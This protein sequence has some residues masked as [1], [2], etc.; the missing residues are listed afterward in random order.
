MEMDKGIYGVARRGYFEARRLPKNL[1][2]YARSEQLERLYAG[3]NA[4]GSISQLQPNPNGQLAE[5]QYPPY[6]IGQASHTASVGS[7]IPYVQLFNRDTVGKIIIDGIKVWGSSASQV[8]MF[9]VDA[10]VGSANT[11][12][13]GYPRN[14]SYLRWISAW[15]ECRHGEALT[16]FTGYDVIGTFYMAAN[17]PVDCYRNNLFLDEF[18]LEP[19]WG[20]VLTPVLATGRFGIVVEFHEDR[21]IPPPEGGSI[22]GVMGI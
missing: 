6:Y 7:M 13:E 15:G 11:L 14:K 3:E 18:I 2:N 22:T 8:N 12:A 10:A 4:A 19:Q 9:F 1:D 20:I 5:T 16:A 21:I 17:V